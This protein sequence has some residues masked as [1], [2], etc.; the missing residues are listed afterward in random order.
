MHNIMFQATF[1]GNLN[2][3]L[4]FIFHRLF[5]EEDTKNLPELNTS[6]LKDE[7]RRLIM[8]KPLFFSLLILLSAIPPLAQGKAAKD[9]SYVFGGGKVTQIGI[10]VRDIE[11]AS[12][13]YAAFL[14][15][16]KPQWFLTDEVDKAHTVFKGNSTEARAKLAFFELENITIE[17]I[18]PV[19]GPSTWQEFLENKGEGIHHIAF[20]IKDMDNK[21]DLLSKESIDLLQKGDYEGGRYSYLD[22]FSRLGLIIELLENFGQEEK[23][24][25]LA[26]EVPPEGRNFIPVKV[27]SKEEDKEILS[28]YEGL[29][30]ADVS[31]G[32]DKAGL[33]GIGLVDP[34]ILPLWS[35]TQEYTHRMAGIA[36]TARYVP[37]QRPAAGSKTPEEFD[38]WEGHFYTHYSSEPYAEL[39]REGTV[40]VID[41]VEGADIGT[42]GSYNI[43]D[44]KLRG[45]VG[46]VTD[47]AA[48]D[49]DEII[50]QRI[51]LYLHQRGRG[52]RP[53]RNEIE[54]VNR[55]VSIGGVLVIPGDVVVAD[56]DGV[57]VVPRSWA[58]QVAGFA[59]EI[60]EK[61][62][63]GRRELY[64][65]LGLPED[66]SIKH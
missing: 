1:A 22:G 39:I 41:D 59:R 2:P 26:G 16:D 27:F 36:V 40:L 13:A 55:P 45:C 30:V 6:T 61:D 47:A 28:L 52:I 19:G 60:M 11:T 48:R 12:Q 15:M 43:M 17:L 53:G 50:T 25:D 62:K 37:T 21:I 20:E 58:R 57:V 24:S 29:R 65:R 33:P 14:G 46:V 63:A 64:Q 3:S 56:G 8:K 31:D 4:S 54:S 18:E 35:D 38:Q 44:W 51:P 10:V 49:T 34:G 66:K 23:T 32:M 42:I 5:V 9:T 7:S